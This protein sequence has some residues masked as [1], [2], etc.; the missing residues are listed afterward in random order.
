MILRRIGIAAAA[1]L[2]T[3]AV[4]SVALRHQ[5]VIELR[6]QNQALREALEQRRSLAEENARLYRLA[7]VAP[8]GQSGGHQSELI[9]LRNETGRLRAHRQEWEA[10]C[11]ENRQLRAELGDA[12]QP[13][14]SRENWAY[15]GYGDPVSACQSHFCATVSRDP[16]TFLDSLCP[17]ARASWSQC[18]E[19]ELAA[20]FAKVEK[21]SR[22]IPSFQLL[23]Q[24]KL[25]DEEVELILNVYPDR[26]DIENLRLTFKRVGTEWKLY[27]HF[28][29]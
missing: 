23:G 8:A 3:G 29:H 26:P 17:E 24:K 4:V 13:P 14:V 28:A 11:A 20:Q 19:A 7:A 25:S 27:G 2:V 22:N 15:V 1:L 6:R 12:V 18:S 10:L 9:R 5:A 21:V 16:S